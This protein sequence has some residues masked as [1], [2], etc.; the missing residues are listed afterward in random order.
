MAF[1]VFF[2]SALFIWCWWDS[3]GF[4]WCGKS[5]P[6]PGCPM[7]LRSGPQAG[8]GFP[9]LVLTV[10]GSPLTCTSWPPSVSRQERIGPLLVVVSCSRSFQMPGCL[11]VRRGVSAQ[12][13]RRSCTLVDKWWGGSYYPLLLPVPGLLLSNPRKEGGPHELPSV[14]V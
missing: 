10:T 3:L 12:Q 7:S 2:S 6:K 9:G 14:A 4:C 11:S 13:G 5:F 8:R 1:T